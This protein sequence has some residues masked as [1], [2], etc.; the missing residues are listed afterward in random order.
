MVGAQGLCRTVSGVVA[1]D[2]QSTRQVYMLE[3]H[4][5]ILLPSMKNNML[6][7]MQMR[8]NDAKCN[9]KPKHMVPNPTDDH[10]A[11]LLPCS[12]D[13][14]VP[15]EL[16][17]IPL[18]FHGVTSCFLTRKTTKSEY[19]S[20]T[21]WFDAMDMMEWWELKVFAGQSVV[22]WLMTT[23]A[24]DR[25]TCWKCTKQFWCNL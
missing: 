5:V 12:Q 16:L 14:T 3:M 13:D 9:D 18:T 4:Q 20:T 15:V 10:N 23:Q 11:I 19:K 21:L 22:W 6:S 17:R 1:Y 8:D 25:Y 7:T 24:L 2:H